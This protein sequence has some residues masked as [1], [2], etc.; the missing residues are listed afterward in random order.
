MC[1]THYRDNLC[2]NPIPAIVH[3]CASWETCMNRDSTKVG[4]AKVGAETTGTVFN[5]FAETITLKTLAS[6]AYL[7]LFGKII[8]T[9]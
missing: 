7:A 3:Q 2:S 9:R 1:A 6:L 8:L 5:A 4:R